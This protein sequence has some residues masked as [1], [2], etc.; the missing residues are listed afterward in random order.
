V[1]ITGEHAEAVSQCPW[2][3]MEE[4]FL[5]NLQPGAQGSLSNRRTSGKSVPSLIRMVPVL[6]ASGTWALLGVYSGT[7]FVSS[8]RRRLGFRWTQSL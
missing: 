3:S 7:F 8:W 2:M 5:T 1:Q 6:T 4:G